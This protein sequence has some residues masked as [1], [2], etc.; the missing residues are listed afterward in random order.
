MPEKNIVVV[1]YPK[2]GNTWLSR[3]V[4]ELI[5]CPV[6]GFWK[7]P[8]NQDIAI[9]GENRVSDYAV[10]KAHHSFPL[11]LEDAPHLLPQNI[12]CIVRDV[13][14][15]AISGAHFFEFP[16]SPCTWKVRI[17][18]P[19]IGVLKIT[20]LFNES[21]ERQRKIW[22]MIEVLDKGS[23]SMTRWLRIPWDVH[24]QGYLDNGIFLVRYED[25][26]A[27]P[28]TQCK[29]ILAH[30]EIERDEESIREAVRRQQFD[31][32]KTKFLEQGDRKC[33][34][35]LRQGKSGVW[36]HELTLHQK[37]FLRRRFSDTLRA[38]RNLP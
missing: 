34:N 1:G 33:A 20:L 3:L 21:F 26:L 24:V 25:M 9:E 6:R 14:D 10:F 32:V 23:N 27:E 2:S 35:F 31:T 18:V 22:K 28:V 5:G 29:R 8:Q 15:I 4:A 17:K 36:K 30:L 37:W 7:E 38:L 19:L 11:I 12:I 16:L 13:R